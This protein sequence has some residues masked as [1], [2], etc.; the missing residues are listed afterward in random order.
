[1]PMPHKEFLGIVAVLALGIVIFV[2]S[3]V[4]SFGQDLLSG[5]RPD[6]SVAV[7]P[8]EKFYAPSEFLPPACNCSLVSDMGGKAVYAADCGNL[9]ENKIIE[10]A[11]R[12]LARSGY[13]PDWAIQK[14]NSS[15]ISYAKRHSVTGNACSYIEMGFLFH[16][17]MNATVENGGPC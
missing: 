16:R 2:G 3:S 1:M 4:I 10:Y 14:R 7:A 13:E 11:H 6:V 9:N 8:P 5:S 17:L 12:R 15:F